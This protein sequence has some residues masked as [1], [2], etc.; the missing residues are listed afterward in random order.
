[1]SIQAVIFDVGGVLLRVQDRRARR[2]W[3]AHLGLAEGTLFKAIVTSQVSARAMVGE[4]SEEA[5]WKHAAASFKLNAEQS[6]AFQR[7]FWSG[8]RLNAELVR[9]MRA[10]RR[11][12]KVAILSNAWSDT[13]EEFSQR[14]G[15][16]RLADA[17]I[18]S[19]EEGVA[20]PDP[21]IYHI[22]VERLGVRAEAAV[23]VDDLPENVQGAQAVGM[24]GVQ[25]KNNA[26]TIAEIKRHL[27]DSV[28]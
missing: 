7:D 22:A 21:R 24:R 13:R 25:F 10:L 28:L 4:V 26:Q 1:M 2:K 5:V 19:A 17:M 9:F 12:F 11:R 6:R 27:E 8:N 20:K 16:D 14:F 23:F 3:E 15:L 18:I